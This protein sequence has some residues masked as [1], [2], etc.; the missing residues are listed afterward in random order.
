M[1]LDALVRDTAAALAAPSTLDSLARDPYWPKWEGGWWQMLL[2]W[3]LGCARAIPRA[4][5]DALADSLDRNCMHEFPLRVEDVPAG[6]D[7]IRGVPCHCQLG[8]VYQV[9]HAC[10]VDVDARLP[11][12]RPWFLRYQLPDGGLNCDEAVYLR[13]RPR[14]SIVSTLPPLEAILHCTPRDFTPEEARFLD[15]GAEYLLARR[16]WRS[17]SKGGAVIDESWG[18][19]TF[20][21][22][23][24]YDLLRGLAFLARWAEVRGRALPREATAEAVAAIERASLP[25]GTLAPGRRAVDGTKTLRRDARG[26][27]QKGQPAGSFPLLDVVGA[28]GVSSPW[29]TRE[30]DV[31]RGRL[32]SMA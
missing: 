23:Y 25:D 3:E 31:T 2:L 1:D 15:R 13:E 30:W 14:S 11:W 22:Y 7:P 18:R 20:P 17:L 12:L 24:L 9:L 4:A 19:L 8:T 27:W 26:E 32:A 21:R 6:R 29:L 10:G 5:A 16:L 28:P